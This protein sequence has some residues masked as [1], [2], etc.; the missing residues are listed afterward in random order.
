MVFRVARASLLLAVFLFASCF[1]ARADEARNALV[2][3]NSSYTFAPL[4]IPETMPRIS[5]MRF[6]APA[7]RSTSSWTPARPGC[8]RRLAA[9][10]VL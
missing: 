2:I 8:W 10:A 3:G 7:S 1:A 4:P 6:A 9:S 5:R